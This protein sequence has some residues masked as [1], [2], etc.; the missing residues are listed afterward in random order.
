[1][2]DALPLTGSGK[3]QESRLRESWRAGEFV[4]I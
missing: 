3:I 2:L 4:W 1:V